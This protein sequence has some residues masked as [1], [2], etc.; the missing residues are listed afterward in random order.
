MK[1]SL[2]VF[3]FSISVFAEDPACLNEAAISDIKLS[4]KVETRDIEKFDRCV[5]K[6]NTYKIFQALSLFK[7]IR[8]RHSLEI[9]EP[10]DQ[11]IL[12]SDFWTY[13]KERAH[14]VVD[15][16]KFCDGSNAYVN[17]GSKDGIIHIC[18][19]F[20]MDQMNAY[21]RAIIM[22]HE[23]RHF[24]GF[25]HT[26][27]KR[28]PRA[29][30]EKACDDKI[31]DKGS[32]AV[33][34][35]GISKMATF[36]DNLPPATKNLLKY[37]AIW[38]TDVAF[39]EVVLPK[40]FSAVYLK[41]KDKAFI[42]DG[43]SMPFPAPV[44]PSNGVLSS[45]KTTIQFFPTDKSDAIAI[46]VM[47]P[48]FNSVP[49]TGKFALEYNMTPKEQRSEVKIVLNGSYSLCRVLEKT[50]HCSL[51]ADFFPIE[52]KMVLDFKV[53]GIFESFEIGSTVRNAVYLLSDND[54]LYQIKIGQ[55]SLVS[56][57]ITTH[58]LQGFKALSVVNGKTLGLSKTGQI[59]SYEKG[60]LPNEILKEQS[61]EVMTKP[62]FWTEHFYQ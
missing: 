33:T 1:S 12:P 22:L 49:A 14:Q 48:K 8:F 53:N 59:R 34:V 36:A 7:N 20:Y 31:S 30:M 17:G 62:F 55:D 52:R 3:L 58:P 10:F 51:E 9:K 46:D 26:A 38:W 6:T 2:I 29:G 24:E 27:C 5:P 37:M 41:S 56:E 35:E 42:F 4:I 15:E 40:G 28:G 16:R 18:G 57:K 11:G 50:L 45:R 32:Y 61:F 13:F 25:R 39:N 44:L 43:I 54:E 47:D 19:P 60:W 23:A 21:E